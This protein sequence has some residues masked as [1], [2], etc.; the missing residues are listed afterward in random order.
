VGLF[1]SVIVVAFQSAFH[2]EMHQNDVFLYLKNCFWD[3]RIKT[4][5]NIKKILI[6]S[7][8]KFLNFLETQVGPP[9]QMLSKLTCMRISYGKITCFYRKAH[10]MVVQVILKLEV[11]ELSY[12]ESVY[13]KS[14]LLF[15]VEGEK[16]V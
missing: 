7:K 14:C 1:K 15:P 6:F 16:S 2:V 5:Q 9:F 10:M 13:R 4:I 3:Q 8:K 12:I 11:S